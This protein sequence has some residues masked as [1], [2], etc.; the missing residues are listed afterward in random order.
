MAVYFGQALFPVSEGG[1]ASTSSSQPPKSVFSTDIPGL[2]NVMTAQSFRTAH[3]LGNLDYRFTPSPLQ[4]NPL[5]STDYPEL[6][7]RFQA[8]GEVK[9][10]GVSLKFGEH[11]HDVLLPDQATDMRFSDSYNLSLRSPLLDP[12]IK[13]FSDSVVANIKSGGRLTAPPEISIEVPRWVLPGYTR[14]NP[15]TRTITYLF[16]GIAHQQTLLS[17]YHEHLSALNVIQQGTLGSKGGAFSLK[18]MSHAKGSTEESA[19]SSLGWNDLERSGNFVDLA[20]E[21]A[22]SITKAS[23]S[24][25]P[26]AKVWR[27]RAEMSARKQRRSATSSEITLSQPPNT[28]SEEETPPSVTE[29]YTSPEDATD[30]EKRDTLAPSISP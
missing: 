29:D 6:R 26:L 15:N 18:H 30:S 21:L 4:R 24:Q 10:K 5:N 28:A 23:A 8:H 3:G 25:V 7:I 13:E 11:H 27:P 12:N 17:P 22:E 2:A 19:G 9:L 1:G 20:F 14:N 16:A